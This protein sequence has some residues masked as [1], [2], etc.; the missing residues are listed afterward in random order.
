MRR[1]QAERSRELLLDCAAEELWRH[2]LGGTR[3]QDVL[4]RAGMTKGGLYHHFTGKQELADALA[5]EEAGRW[6]AVLDAAVADLRGLAAVEALMAA[7][8]ARYDSDV[9][10]RAVLRMVEEL[11]EGAVTSAFAL[12]QDAVARA[13]QQ[14]IADREVADDVPLREVA[15]AVVDAL[16]GVCT[17]PAPDSRGVAATVRAAR[18][19]RLLLGGLRAR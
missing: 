19:S 17:S 11:P 15:A 1:E 18:V 13:L 8:A 9:R 3:I 7:V 12:W 2:G 5:A 14:A 6:P 10:V 4:D 16:H